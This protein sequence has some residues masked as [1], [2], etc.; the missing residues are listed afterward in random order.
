MSECLQDEEEHVVFQPTAQVETC[1]DEPVT[2]VTLTYYD[3]HE[4]TLKSV[5]YKSM[6]ENE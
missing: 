1:D 4:Q 6:L 3:T 2:Y 5:A